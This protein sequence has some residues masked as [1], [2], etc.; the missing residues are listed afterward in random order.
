MRIGPR[1]SIEL[2]VF[3]HRKVMTFHGE[4]VSKVNR[5]NSGP[6]S[7]CYDSIV[8]PHGLIVGHGGRIRKG[9]MNGCPFK[10]K[11]QLGMLLGKARTEGF[12]GK[13][14]ALREWEE[15]RVSRDGEGWRMR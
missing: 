12:K 3:D 15:L 5:N 14:M 7:G 13:G 8:S 10:F 1:T 2:A 11:T 4:I 6:G 9:P